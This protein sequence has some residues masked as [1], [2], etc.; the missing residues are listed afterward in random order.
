MAVVPPWYVLDV[1][2]RTCEFDVAAVPVPLF[3][4]CQSTPNEPPDD[5]LLGL[6]VTFNGCTSTVEDAVT[7]KAADTA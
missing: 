7:V 1:L 3:R 5:T 4:I 2:I 6:R